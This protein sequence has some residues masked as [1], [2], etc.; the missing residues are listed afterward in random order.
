MMKRHRDPRLRICGSHEA[1]FTFLEMLVATGIVTLLGAAVMVSFA[2]SRKARDLAISG[3]NAL[4]VLKVAQGK[5]L[6]GEN[7]LPWGVR[8]EANRYILF[9]G[10]TFVGSGHTTVYNLPAGIEIAGVILA[11]GGQEAVFKRLDGRTD[12]A[13]T[14][15]IRV[16][17]SP[18]EIFQ[19]T[20]DSAGH[21]YRTGTASVPAATR[22]TDARH[23]NFTLGWSIENASAMTLTFANPP[24]PDVVRQITM[25]PAPPRTSFDWSESIEVGNVLQTLRLHAVSLTGANTVLSVDRDCRTN[26]KKLSI[27]IDGKPIATYEA[28]CATVTVGSFGGIMAEP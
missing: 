13:G 4:L 15:D 1:G 14:F 23:R 22:V 26:A 11:G 25:T 24:G 19:V 3:Q 12:Q 6:A 21:A 28:D 9:S 20:I 27:A 8:L 2:S 18:G 17:S 10:P 5:A 16:A 7:A